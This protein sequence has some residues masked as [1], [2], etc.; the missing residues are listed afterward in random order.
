[1]THGRA[2]VQTVDDRRQPGRHGPAPTGWRSL[3]D[4][5]AYPR[6]GAFLPFAD[7]ADG[8]RARTTSPSVESVPTVG[9]HQHHADRRVPRRRP[10]GG[11]RR[12]RAGDGPV[13]R[14]DRH[15]PG[16]GAPAEPARRRSPSR[17]PTA[18]A[19]VRQRR[20]R[21]PRWTRRW[22]RPATTSCAR[23]R[24]SGGPAAT[25]C[26]SA[27][28]WPATSRSPAAAA[29]P[30]GRTRTPRSRCTRTAR[31]RSYT[32]TSP[33]GQ[34]HQTA[35]AMLA[36][37]ELG[38]PVDKITLEWGDTDLVPARRRHRRLAQPAAGRGRG[39]AGVPGAARRGPAS[40]PPT[41]SRPTAADLRFD[42]DAVG[43]R[44]W[45]A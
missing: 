27:S 28:A 45:P 17:T 40:G 7:P 2:Q 34:G 11:D 26:S 19:R 37:E 42:L 29:R 13:R 35:W 33:H 5:G 3:Q 16:R 41:R 21:R 38:I 12:G 9:G 32:G 4:A 36:S 43:V 44:A 8:A 30:A 15:G 25:W 14:R 22:R 24:P 20:L 10:A 1:M 6:L 31:P 23:S 39:P 18:S